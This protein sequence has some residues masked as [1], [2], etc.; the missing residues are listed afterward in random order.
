MIAALLLVIS[1]VALAQFFL[2]YWRALVLGVAA[3]PLSERFREASPVGEEALGARDFGVLLQLYEM[4]PQ[5]KVEKSRLGAV[6]MYY[7]AVDALGRLAGRLMPRVGAWSEREMAT[8][9][10]YV[11]VRMDQRMARN[12]ECAAALR[13]C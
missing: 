9:T 6:R 1:L 13:S 10:R 4:T 12:M 5:L 8:C 7:R 3:Q 2:Y 11:A